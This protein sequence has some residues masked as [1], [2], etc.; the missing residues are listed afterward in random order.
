MDTDFYVYS[1]VYDVSGIKRVQLF[2]RTDNDGQNPIDNNANEVYTSD[3]QYV[4][5]WTT[6]DMV[7]RSFPKGNFYNWTG[8]CFQNIDVLPDEIGDEYY[9]KVTGYKSVLLDYYMEAEDNNGNVFKSNIQHVWVG[10]GES[11]E[12]ASK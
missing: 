8:N 5:E 3:T 6:Y 2:V 9:Y 1:F 7:G 10:S 4:S 11:Q 12:L